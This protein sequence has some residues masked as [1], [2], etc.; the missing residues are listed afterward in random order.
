MDTLATFAKAHG[1]SPQRCRK[2]ASEGRIGAFIDQEWIAAQKVGPRAWIVPE[3]AVVI[4]PHKS[5]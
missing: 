2:L 5:K 4:P 3:G 1:L